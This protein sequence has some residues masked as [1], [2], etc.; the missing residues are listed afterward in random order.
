[1]AN[2][3]HEA[4][5]PYVTA[6]VRFSLLEGLLVFCTAGLYLPVW[7]FLATRDMRRISDDDE[8]RLNV[9][10]WPAFF[11]YLWMILF[12]SCGLFFAIVSVVEVE[13]VYRVMVSVGS[14]I[15]FMFLHARLNTLRKRCKTESVAVRRWGYNSLEWIMVLVFTPIILL[16]FLYTYVNSD[17][18]KNLRAKKLIQQEQALQER[19]EA[20]KEQLE[21][22]QEEAKEKQEDN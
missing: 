12:F 6:P 3:Q 11:D 10:G 8:I 21:A 7:F 2:T 16:L 15:I 4:S 9:R 18:H 5:A 22:K 17:L 20:H 19:L 13:T 1:M 14:V